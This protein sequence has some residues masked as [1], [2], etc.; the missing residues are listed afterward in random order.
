[1]TKLKH[2]AVEKV[3]CALSTPENH[4]QQEQCC[5]EISEIVSSDEALC[6][7]ISQKSLL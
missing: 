5:V 3:G 2:R 6:T 4:V 7:L 1:M